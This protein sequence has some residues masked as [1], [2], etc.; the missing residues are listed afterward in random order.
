MTHDLNEA[1]Y[2]ADEV[3]VMS[4]GPGTIRRVLPVP[5]ERPR[6]I[7]SL[8]ESREF[9]ELYNDLWSLFKSQLQTSEAGA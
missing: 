3:I 8:V 1:I 7:G 6:S 9:S 2:L 4:D 5:F